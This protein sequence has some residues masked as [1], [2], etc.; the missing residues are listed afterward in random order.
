[1]SHHARGAGALALV[2]VPS[3]AALLVGASCSVGDQPEKTPAQLVKAAATA[4]S[5]AHTLSMQGVFTDADV[6]YSL[7]VVVQRDNGFSGTVSVG[8]DTIQSL[9]FVNQSAYISGADVVNV[10]G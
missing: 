7:D 3:V 2:L 9:T 4:L 5:R 8:Q 6:P 10:L 1:M